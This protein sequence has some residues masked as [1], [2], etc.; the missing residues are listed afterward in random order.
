MEKFWSSGRNGKESM[1]W[2]YIICLSMNKR[3]MNDFRRVFWVLVDLE[4][5]RSTG[6]KPK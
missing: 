5:V 2:K 6:I 4:K 1:Q 3:T